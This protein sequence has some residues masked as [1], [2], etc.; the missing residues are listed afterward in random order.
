MKKWKNIMLILVYG[1]VPICHAESSALIKLDPMGVP[2]IIQEQGWSSTGSV[3]TG[4]QWACVLDRHNGL[5]WEVKTSDGGYR[6]KAWTYSWFQPDVADA[7]GVAN[8]GRCAVAGQCDTAAYIGTVNQY[9]LCGVADW[10]LPSIDE[11]LT[12][13]DVNYRYPAADI[14]FFPDFNRAF[15]WTMSHHDQEPQGIRTVSF[16]DGQLLWLNK[17]RTESIRLVSSVLPPKLAGLRFA[18]IM[19]GQGVLQGNYRG[20]WVEASK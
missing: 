13:V 19:P 9:G 7:A 15:Y 6:D 18:P 3:N 4:S 5:L 8:G 10:R 12:L 2:L 20:Y 16:D 17:A 1:F 14:R 11:L